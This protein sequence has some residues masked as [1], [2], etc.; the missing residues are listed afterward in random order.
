MDQ[1][2]ARASATMSSRRDDMQRP[3]ERSRRTQHPQGQ[4][5]LMD[6]TELSRRL[7]LCLGQ[8]WRASQLQMNHCPRLSPTSTSFVGVGFR[9]Q[10]RPGLNSELADRKQILTGPRGVRAVMR[11][12]YPQPTAFVSNGAVR[13]MHGERARTVTYS[14]R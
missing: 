13:D 5:A 6:D 14:D 2:R 9:T 12:S 8:A 10:R 3:R 11:P 7:D 1:E 4:M